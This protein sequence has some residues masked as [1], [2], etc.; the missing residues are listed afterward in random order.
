[1]VFSWTLTTLN[2]RSDLSRPLEFRTKVW[3]NI[4]TGNGGPSETWPSKLLDHWCRSFIRYG[5]KQTFHARCY[6]LYDERK[7]P[8]TVSRQPLIERSVKGVPVDSKA[9]K[10]QTPTKTNR[11]ARTGHCIH[12]VILKKENN[13]V[14]GPSQK[15]ERHTMGE[16]VFIALTTS[17]GV[18]TLRQCVSLQEADR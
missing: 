1:M 8:S 11:C 6:R 9:L 10:S 12:T 17:R 18:R 16:T 15:T 3:T 7:N 13:T 14:K 2:F 4:I 5:A